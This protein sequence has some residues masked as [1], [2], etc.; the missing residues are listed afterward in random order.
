VQLKILTFLCFLRWHVLLLQ[1]P[2]NTFCL[3]KE[4][5]M[6][7]REWMA[8]VDT[9]VEDACG[10]SMESLPDWL[11]RDAY[12]EGLTPQEGADECLDNAGFSSFERLV[13]I[14]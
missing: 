13:E 5:I 10:L 11:S 8:A 12:D 3:V 1:L 14:D 7:Y 2:L 9:I 6:T 4:K